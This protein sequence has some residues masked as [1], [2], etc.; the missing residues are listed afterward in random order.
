MLI[1]DFFK[2]A[3]TLSGHPRIIRSTVSAAPVSTV[4]GS[5]QKLFLTQPAGVIEDM[6][7]TFNDVTKAIAEGLKDLSPEDQFRL[8]F[9]R[10]VG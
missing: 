7:N 3:G 4:S 5:S 2:L 10:A 1:F 6:G 9:G 8:I